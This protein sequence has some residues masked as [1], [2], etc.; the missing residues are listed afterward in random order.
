MRTGSIDLVV[1]PA[2]IAAYFCLNSIYTLSNIPVRNIS[3]RLLIYVK[4][5]STPIINESVFKTPYVPGN[6]KIGKEKIFAIPL[7]LLEK[8]FTFKLVEIVDNRPN[9]PFILGPSIMFNT[10]IVTNYIPIYPSH[11]NVSYAI[12]GKGINIHINVNGNIRLKLR[13]LDKT[14]HVHV[15]NVDVKG[16]KSIDTQYYVRLTYEGFTGIIPMYYIADGNVYFRTRDN[17][18]I[19]IIAY[20]LV[21]LPIIMQGKKPTGK[22]PR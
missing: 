13:Y 10:S 16:V 18:P 7:S 5:I 17:I 11:V 2:R 8:S 9:P 3:F 4:G 15:V 19:F 12:L 20:T 1:K 6:L 22:S 14:L 21:L